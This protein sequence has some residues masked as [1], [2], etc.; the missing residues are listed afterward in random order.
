MDTVLL[1]QN[2]THGSIIDCV[3]VDS[4]K[5]AVPLGRY[6]INWIIGGSIN[7]DVEDGCV[8][9][10]YDIADQSISERVE[11]STVPNHYGSSRSFF[12]CPGCGRRVRFLYRPWERLRFRCRSCWR[13]NYPSQQETPGAVGP[14]RNQSLGLTV[15]RGIPSA[16]HLRSRPR[17]TSRKAALCMIP[18]RWQNSKRLGF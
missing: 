5:T 14:Y 17:L 10:L 2:R 12:L 6:A 18:A 1:G 11:L 4:F 16:S 15:C 9:L 3:R 13:L 7:L 8:R